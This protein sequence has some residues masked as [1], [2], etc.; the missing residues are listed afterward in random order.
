VTPA[1]SNPQGPR[2]CYRCG[3]Y[4][5]DQWV[6]ADNRRRLACSA[7]GHI[8]Y[9]NPRVLV[10]CLVE[11]EGSVL[12]CKRAHAPA[13][14]R[15]TPPAGFLEMGESL[16]QAAVR[17][18]REE[19]GIELDPASLDLHMVSSV[20]WMGEVYVGFRATVVDPQIRIGPESAEVRFFREFE[21]PWET[22]AFKETIGYLQLFFRD[23]LRERRAIHLTHIDATGGYR[24]EYR[25]SSHADVFQA[26]VATSRSDP[27]LGNS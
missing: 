16:E 6:A 13:G 25:I 24:R 19:T 8:H 5:V 1:T 22:L 11:C 27:D 26:D 23:R 21:I 4:L 9:E 12:L 7:C 2:H 20:P 15:W 3:A 10:S 14:G 17:E 18:T